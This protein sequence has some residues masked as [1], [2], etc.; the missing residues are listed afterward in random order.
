MLQR[1]RVS[2]FATA[3]L[4]CLALPAMAADKDVGSAPNQDYLDQKAELENLV[5]SRDIELFELDFQPLE[6]DRIVIKDRLDQNRVFHYLAFR[7]RNQISDQTKVNAAQPSRYNEILQQLAKEFE[8]TPEE[9]DGIIKGG[10]DVS[11][12]DENK[13][14]RTHERAVNLSVIAF[15]ENGSRIR[16]LDEPPGSGEQE[17]MN[18]PDQGMTSVDISYRAVR[19]K[20]EEK[21]GR[22]LCTPEEIRAKPLPV[23]NPEQ[24]DEEGVA[25]GEV[26][27]VVLFNDLSIYGDEF[28]VFV[29]GLNN[30][31]RIRRAGEEKAEPSQLQETP[32]GE[33]DNYLE[34]R[35]LRRVY[36]LHYAR[37]G[38]EYFQD[39]DRIT[40]TK[41]GWEWVDTF[42]RVQQRANVAYVR[43]FFDNIVDKDNERNTQVEAEFWPYYNHVREQHANVPPEK[44]PDLE[45]TLQD[46]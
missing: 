2:G 21:L 24:L 25:A 35:L 46:R 8:S 1:A 45:K 32:K 4:S 16:L 28:T 34:A 3:I 14:Q 13:P 10:N 39:Q 22:R 9:A 44:L 19:D 40:L 31:F 30:K 12:L 11:A 38:D 27:G 26:Y 29:R 33:L 20:V 7:I 43:Y 17:K 42:Q 5:N 23:Y 36:V 41:G 6:F 15:D 37:P 18:F